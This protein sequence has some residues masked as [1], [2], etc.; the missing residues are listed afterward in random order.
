MQIA[1][2]DDL[3]GITVDPTGGPQGPFFTKD[4]SLYGDKINWKHICEVN[5]DIWLDDEKRIDYI[6]MF[7]SLKTIISK[8]QLLQYIDRISSDL[9]FESKHG[10]HS[11]YKNKL[12]N[13]KEDKKPFIHFTFDNVFSKNEINEIK[14]LFNTLDFKSEEKEEVRQVYTVKRLDYKNNKLITNIVDK[15][16]DGENGFAKKWFNPIVMERAGITKDEDVKEY[17]IQSIENGEVINDANKEFLNSEF[18]RLGITPPATDNTTTQE[19]ARESAVEVNNETEGLTIINSKTGEVVEMSGANVT[20][21]KINKDGT[22]ENNSTN[23]FIA[24][25]T[26]VEVDPIYQDQKAQEKQESL[27][28]ELAKKAVKSIKQI[29]PD[30]QVVLHRTEAA[31]NKATN[32]NSQGSKGKGGSRGMYSPMLAL[33]NMHHSLSSGCICVHS[34]RKKTCS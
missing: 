33:Q 29:L 21:P 8:D 1:P 3:N 24:D 31:Y 20:T 34:A 30:V 22:I 14:E 5:K 26:V 6:E 28:T 27:I 16:A 12:I 10:Y 2:H 32:Q 7:G 15:I 17:Y 11:Y 13:F 4:L 23:L 18:E 9:S 19:V 25:D